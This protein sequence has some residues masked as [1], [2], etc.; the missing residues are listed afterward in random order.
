MYHR[1]IR[2]AFACVLA[3]CVVIA[4]APLRASANPVLEADWQ[5]NGNGS[6]SSGNGNTLA[7]SGTQ[8]T[9]YSYA[10]GGGIVMNGTSS[11]YA[12]MT[13]DNTAFDFGTT[14]FTLQAWV[15]Y[16]GTPGIENLVEKFSGTMGPGWTIWAQNNQF[17]FFTGTNG[18][19]AYVAAP[20]SSDGW[21]DLVV[22]DNG[23][24]TSMYVNNVLMA[25]VNNVNWG[26][27]TD[28]LFIG[29]R[30]PA[31][32][33]Y[34]TNGTIYDVAIWNGSLS[35]KQMTSV[36]NSGVPAPIA[37]PEPAQGLLLVGALVLLRRRRRTA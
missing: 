11:D 7:I 16:N 35:S 17:V 10:P 20:L 26:S 3:L 8:G 2:A 27:S 34:P 5:F 18:D 21:V 28:P 9:D 13:T 32:Q 29:N 30:N 15:K 6:D 33:N 24:V 1:F 12:A 19:I 14:N 36:Y 4:F 23:G 31:V 37:T 22:T 25:S